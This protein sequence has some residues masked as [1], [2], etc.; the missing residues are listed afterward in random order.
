MCVLLYKNRNAPVGENFLDMIES[1]IPKRFEIFHTVRGFLDR[2]RH[3]KHYNLIAILLV[4][5]KRELDE[6]ISIR[7]WLLDLRVIL[8][9]PPDDENMVKKGSLLYPRYTTYADSD[10][11]HIADVLKKMIQ[12]EHLSGAFD[13]MN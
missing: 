10:F 9:L 11:E 5:D 6:F 12:N 13:C 3:R 8:I 1:R 7:E 2:L 4:S